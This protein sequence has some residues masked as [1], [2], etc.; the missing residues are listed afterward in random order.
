VRHFKTQEG[1][2]HLSDVGTFVVARL[3][4]SG[5]PD[6]RLELGSRRQAPEGH[7]LLR[8]SLRSDHSGQPYRSLS[9]FSLIL[10]SIRFHDRWNNQY[11]NTMSYQVYGNTALDHTSRDVCYVDRVEFEGET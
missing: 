6:H 9:L 5:S 1:V 2:Y 4:E 10:L 3:C 8:L 11:A 7:C